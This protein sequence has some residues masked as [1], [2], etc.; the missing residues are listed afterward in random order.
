[1]QNESR[2]PK[3]ID[4]FLYHYI[5]ISHEPLHESWPEGH[6][7]EGLFFSFFGRIFLERELQQKNMNFTNS[8]KK[9]NAKRQTSLLN[10]PCDAMIFRILTRLGTMYL[11]TKLH[12]LFSH[13]C[14]ISRTSTSISF[15]AGS[16]TPLSSAFSR[17]LTMM[18][19]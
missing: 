5:L 7:N 14:H 19:F 9:K 6:L 2:F 8:T 15:G 1:M 11:T 12:F 18:I 3:Y 17:R 16:N 4:V 10:C 13:G